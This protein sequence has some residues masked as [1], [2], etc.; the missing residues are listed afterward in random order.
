MNTTASNKAI[1]VA[2]IVLI[3]GV[4]TFALDAPLLS[5][6]LSLLVFMLNF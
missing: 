2:L 6:L 4:G 5:G 3:M 1:A